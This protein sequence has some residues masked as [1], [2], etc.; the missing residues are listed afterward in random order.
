M[1]KGGGQVTSRG[2]V[3]MS[4]SPGAEF[5]VIWLHESLIGQCCHQAVE[6]SK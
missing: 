2:G 5:S 6:D 1:C 4:I 3:V